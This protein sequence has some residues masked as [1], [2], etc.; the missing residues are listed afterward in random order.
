ML[1]SFSLLSPFLS[2][3]HLFHPTYPPHCQ[4]LCYH[5]TKRFNLWRIGTV[6]PISSVQNL[7]Y[8][9]KT[10]FVSFLGRK[11]SLK[12]FK[13]GQFSTWPMFCT[14]LPLLVQICS[15]KFLNVNHI[16]F[17]YVRLSCFSPP[18]LHIILF[19]KSLFTRQGV[20]TNWN[21]NKLWVINS[22]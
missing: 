15:L 12:V 22:G 13:N 7:M 11:K 4:H 18:L 8:N 16:L 14:L 10:T 17:C 21:K 9:F 2:D 19:Y 5:K 6:T 1:H 3:Y 20:R